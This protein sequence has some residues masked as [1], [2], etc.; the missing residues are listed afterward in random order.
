MNASRPPQGAK[1]I[2]QKPSQIYRARTS[3]SPDDS[4]QKPVSEPSKPWQDS[5]RKSQLSLLPTLARLHRRPSVAKK[6][7][8]IQLVAAQRPEEEPKTLEMESSKLKGWKRSD[9]YRR[10]SASIGFSCDEDGVSKLSSADVI[11]VIICWFDF[12]PHHVHLREA[13]PQDNNVALETSPPCLFPPLL[14]PPQYR[15][16]QSLR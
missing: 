14:Y 4:K 16:T 5:S 6:L 1:S 8:Q 7:K 2:S 10:R 3:R 12:R 15:R 9:A 13:L 11:E